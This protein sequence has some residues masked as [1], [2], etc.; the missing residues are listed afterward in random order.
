MS[1][2]WKSGEQSGPR[3][4]L[5]EAML[6]RRQHLLRFPADLEAQFEN[7]TGRDRCR[8]FVRYG[9]MG[10][11]LC[12][13]FLLNYFSLLPDV[14][15][16]ELLAQFAL[17]TPAVVVVTFYMRAEPP[18]F[19]RELIQSCAALT[20][21]IVPMIIYQ[22]SVYPA[23][24]FFR[25]A[26]IL[27]LLYINVVAA[28]RFRFALPAS[29]ATVLC[30]IVDL[31]L[32]KGVSSDVKTLVATSVITTCGFTLLANHRL[33]RE[34]R[35]TYLLNE[36][37][38]LQRDEIIRL[39]SERAVEAAR[40]ARE[41]EQAASE[42]AA[43]AAELRNA[44]RIAKIATWGLDLAD[45]QLTM[46]N[47]CTSSWAPT[48]KP[49]GRRGRPCSTSFIPT[50]GPRSMAPSRARPPARRRWSRNG[51]CAG[52]TATAPGSGPRCTSS[53][54][55]SASLPRSAWCART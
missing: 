43:H 49:S 20:G 41:R 52:T 27:T 53:A 29:A 13:M 37:E 34:Q 18:V 46:S 55:P 28:V 33:E 39:A 31:W 4:E 36:R 32:L 6:D 1:I 10:F 3:A 54:T 38:S 9:L 2:Q 15:W 16:R 26:P 24:I 51:A 45:G 17:V 19:Q 40:H 14:A 5:I 7:K 30:S 11:V 44:H 42:S 8:G 47:E 21:L 22:K 23:A 50:T 35:R 48:L 12:N 25:Y